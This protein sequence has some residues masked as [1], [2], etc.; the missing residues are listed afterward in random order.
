[1]VICYNLYAIFI[2]ILALLFRY[3]VI[4]TAPL[5]GYWRLIGLWLLGFSI[6]HT[7]GIPMV[8]AQ[9]ANLPI[10]SNKP[11]QWKTF[12][13]FD[14]SFTVEFPTEPS[15]GCDIVNTPN[16]KIKIIEYISKS[17]GIL[18]AV[19]YGDY[20]GSALSG[21]TPEQILDVIKNHAIE[22]VREKVLSEVSISKA[23]YPG[24]EITVRVEPNMVL[25][26]QIIL[27]DNRFYQLLVITPRDKL[28]TSQ[29]RRFFGS[30]KIAQ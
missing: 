12:V 27:K 28:F 2:S 17:K 6:T 29:I 9:T 21:L 13:S 4:K 11:L 5:N 18:Y 10:S 25:S 26:T 16:G 15:R 20:P 24:R 14:K 7:I 1:M 22:N 3:H 30:F 23:G 8:K 19:M